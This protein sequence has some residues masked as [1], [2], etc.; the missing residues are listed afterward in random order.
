MI[1]KK[2][3][4]QNTLPQIIGKSPS[5]QSQ[6]ILKAMQFNTTLGQ[7][8]VVADDEG[9]YLLEFADRRDLEKE[10]ERLRQ[11][12]NATIIPKETVI[13]N[14]IAKEMSQYFDGTLHQFKTPLKTIGSS[15]QKQVWVELQ[16]IPFGE[17]KSYLGLAKTI[18]RPTACRAV[19]R[20]NSTNQLAIIIPCHRVINSNGELGGYAG[21]VTR[22][23]WLLDHEKK[24]KQQ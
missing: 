19:A 11:K 23:Q 20:A 9:L 21:G 7:M 12:L 8:I 16:Q 1:T 10:V 14:N 18:G 24:F 17:T 5:Q 13:T 4:S 22:K 15:F 2:P 6:C 3:H